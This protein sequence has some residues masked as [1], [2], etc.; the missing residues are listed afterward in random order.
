M[1]FK[2]PNFPSLLWIGK[3]LE[4]CTDKHFKIQSLNVCINWEML[5]SNLSLTVENKMENSHK[6]RQSRFKLNINDWDI[7]FP[8]VFGICQ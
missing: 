2:N 7:L 6:K 4:V 1:V 5:C 8:K 3:N